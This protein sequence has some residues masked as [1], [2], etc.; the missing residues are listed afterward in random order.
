MK[1]PAVDAIPTCAEFGPA[2][3]KVLA[4]AERELAGPV[5]VSI[6]TWEDGEFRIDVRHSHGLI[7][8]DDNRLVSMIHYHSAE[9]NI[10]AGA[11]EVRSDGSETVILQET[12]ENV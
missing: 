6:D 9:K 11:H 7:P 2:L 12:I 8:P 1:D 4:I 3:E 5:S 10:I